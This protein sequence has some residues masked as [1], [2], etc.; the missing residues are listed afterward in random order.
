MAQEFTIGIEEEFQI[1]DPESRELRSRINEMLEEGRMI[2]GEQI[3]PEMHQSMVEVGTGICKNVQE[4][5]ADVCRLRRTLA[6]LADRNGLRIAAA[7]THPFSHW[8]D[9]HITQH[10]RY[11]QL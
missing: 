6:D 5:R 7:S 3:K 11:Y 8:A 9:Q 4:A 2:L 10:E 1:I